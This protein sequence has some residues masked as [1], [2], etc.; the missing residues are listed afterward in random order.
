[1]GQYTRPKLHRMKLRS[2]TCRQE[3][4]LPKLMEDTEHLDQLAYPEVAPTML[5]LLAKDH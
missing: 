1:M 5:E 4:R 3:V 2:R